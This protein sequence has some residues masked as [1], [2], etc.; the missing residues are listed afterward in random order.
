MI[1]MTIREIAE[2]INELS[3]NYEIGNLRQI[4]KD[5]HENPTRMRENSIFSNQTIFD[6]YAYHTGG[7]KE[8]QINIGLIEGQ[9]DCEFLRYG[10]ALSL[11]RGIT[12]RT[13][14]KT[15]RKQFYRL[16]QFIITNEERFSDFF[17]YCHDKN[18]RNYILPNEYPDRL[19]NSLL[20][21]GNFIFFGKK[22]RVSEIDFNDIMETLDR[23]LEIY[24]F[25]EGSEDVPDS[26]VFT[27][28]RKI[29]KEFP[30]RAEYVYA[31]IT[32]K[33]Q[34]IDQRHYRIQ[35]S[36]FKFLSQ[37]FG[38]GMV[39]YEEPTE[40]GTK[41]DLKVIDHEQ[42]YYYEIKTY[43]LAKYCIREALGQLLEYA[44]CSSNPRPNK[45]IIISGAPLTLELKNY[46]RLLRED[47]HL[48]IFYQRFIDEEGRLEDPN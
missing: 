29:K 15:L 10:V 30:E 19:N 14:V 34:K 4:R 45:L 16:F 23:A 46:L 17:F 11:E 32:A 22:V 44:Y 12:L 43:S 5:I 2:R 48:P 42:I 39:Q 24:I 21:E 36:V 3:I 26:E 35:K 18:D 33:T 47:L 28:D 1:L 31:K 6:D 27:Y 8:L 9:D 37:Q 41:I 38:E 20:E 40:Y 25:V 13:P 7:R